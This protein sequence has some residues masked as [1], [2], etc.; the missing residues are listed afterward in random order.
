MADIFI[1]YTNTDRPVAQLLAHTLESLN[2][3][4]WW[5]RKILAG[6]QFDV[7]IERELD[8]AGCVVVLWSPE[9]VNSKWCKNE[10]ATASERDALVPAIVQK[11]RLPLAFRGDQT[12]DLCQWNGSTSHP[13]FRDLLAGIN[14]KLSA[15][16][17]VAER[18][19]SVFYSHKKAA[20]FSKHKFSFAVGGT[21]IGAFSIFIA[22][23][24]FDYFPYKNKEPISNIEPP[25]REIIKP[26]VLENT[27][28][29][30]NTPS[31]FSK[32]SPKPNRESP[33]PQIAPK[34]R[35]LQGPAVSTLSKELTSSN[36]I[37]TPLPSRSALETSNPLSQEKSIQIRYAY[38]DPSAVSAGE[39]SIVKVLYLAASHSREI[40]LIQVISF[41]F[42]LPDGTY[43]S[44]DPKIDK[45]VVEP[46]LHVVSIP[47]DIPREILSGTLLTTIRIEANGQSEESVQ[48]LLITGEAH[49]LDLAKTEASRQRVIF[50][51]MAKAQR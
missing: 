46:G 35:P 30:S 22:A 15:E 26:P 41:R 38:M 8:S 20:Y 10:A 14:A 36:P 34:N 33:F 45:I 44:S 28:E 39:K 13:G 25:I 51:N 29:N 40:Q 27:G 32:E 21:L 18:T 50:N 5:D 4:V 9:S 2:R 31:S 49:R 7:E 6:N 47:I 37:L 17:K 24:K 48:E 12:A 1:S 23:L 11:T 43:Q 19:A 16:Q 42:R 3:S